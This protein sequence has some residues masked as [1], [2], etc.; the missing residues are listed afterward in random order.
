MDPIGQYMGN[1]PSTLFSDHTPRMLAVGSTT[2]A[3]GE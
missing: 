2:R 1:I 3:G